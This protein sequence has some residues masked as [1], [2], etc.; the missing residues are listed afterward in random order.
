[1]NPSRERK[2]NETYD[3]PFL[4]VMYVPQAK[5]GPGT[6]TCEI[7]AILPVNRVVHRLSVLQVQVLRAG[8]RKSASRP[9]FS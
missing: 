1:M 8:Q 7:Q 4:L 3:V 2:V 6:G 5:G 9:V